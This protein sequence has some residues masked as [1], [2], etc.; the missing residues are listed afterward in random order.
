MDAMIY[1]LDLEMTHTRHFHSSCTGRDVLTRL[2]L[3]VMEAGECSLLRVYHPATNL[4]C[5]GKTNFSLHLEV[6]STNGLPLSKT[7]VTDT[8]NICIDW[9][10]VVW[11]QLLTIEA[12]KCSL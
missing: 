12:G 6:C 5:G 8:R 3:G 11:P 7:R 9:N 2:H 4:L 1:A 10:T